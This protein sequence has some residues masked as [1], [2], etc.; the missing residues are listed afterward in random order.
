MPPHAETETTGVLFES[1]VQTNDGGL[2]K[3]VSHLKHAGDKKIVLVWSN[4]IWFILLH[5]ASVYALYL[6]VTDTKW[7][8]NT[9][10]FVCYLMSGLGITAGVHRLWAH[11]AFKAKWP[12]RLTLMVWNT[13]A[14]QD[15]VIDWSRDH[16]VHHKYSDTDAD[17]H[18]AVRGFFFSHVGWLCCRK[19]EEVKRKG[20]QIDMSDLYADPILAFQKK[21]YMK[22]MPLICFVIPTVIPVYFWNESWVNAFCVPTILRYAIV[23][24]ATWS[25][26]SFAHFFGHR[27]YD[28]NLNPREN[29][30]VAMVALGEGFHNF[31]HTFP[32]DYKA[33]ELPFYTLPN[34]CT[35]FID[36]MA[37]IGQASDLKSVSNDV[38]KRRT[39]RTGDGTHKVWGLEDADI[40]PEEKD[41]TDISYKQ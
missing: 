38:V 15:S 18:N 22:L 11:K 37:W 23:L 28:N 1:D 10:A 32:W 12:L 3:E 40:T 29:I 34:P 41:V 25:V 19:N 20:R 13:M 5:S 4:I 7:Q 8:T 30:G 35:A 16:R 14:F 9:F 39:L 36:F 21:H 31:H 6:A 17:P 2:N 26:N 33:S 24:N 27:P